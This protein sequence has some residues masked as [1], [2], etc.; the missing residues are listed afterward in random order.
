M[1]QYVRLVIVPLFLLK[2]PASHAGS[3]FETYGDIGQIVIPVA[4]ALISWGRMI[5]RG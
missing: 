5:S 4:A 3:G 2:V 1:T